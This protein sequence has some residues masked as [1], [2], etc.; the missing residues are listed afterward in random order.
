LLVGHAITP[1]GWVVMVLRG[2]GR[3]LPTV[4]STSTGG[5]R[6]TGARPRRVSM[7]HPFA[8]SDCS[9]TERTA[10]LASCAA[11]GASDGRNGR[12]ARFGPF[13]R[14]GVPQLFAPRL[15]KR[16]SPTS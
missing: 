12:R 14:G 10:P 16:T 15:P 4:L 6:K 9:S 2:A 5:A 1:S 13:P 3:R 7:R 11:G 8:G